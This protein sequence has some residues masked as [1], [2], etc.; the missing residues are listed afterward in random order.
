M[1][2]KMLFLAG[3]ITNEYGTPQECGSM[4]TQLC[5]SIVYIWGKICNK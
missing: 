5:F 3:K 4:V 2:S 1:F